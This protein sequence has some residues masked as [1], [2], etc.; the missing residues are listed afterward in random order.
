M[1]SNIGN[2]NVAQSALPFLCLIFSRCGRRKAVQREHRFDPL[3]QLSDYSIASNSPV[4]FLMRMCFRGTAFSAPR[5]IFL[6]WH[7][8]SLSGAKPGWQCSVDRRVFLPVLGPPLEQIPA[9]HMPVFP[10]GDCY[11]RWT[12]FISIWLKAL[13]ATLMGYVR[14]VNLGRCF[15]QGHFALALPA[16]PR[17]VLFRAD[18]FRRVATGTA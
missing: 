8:A 6:V 9:P 12:P 15:C 5:Q 2:G 4:L 3:D 14:L 17:A 11:M 13:C 10:P 16:Y 18:I 7:N 1:T